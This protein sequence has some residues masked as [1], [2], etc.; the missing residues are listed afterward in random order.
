MVHELSLLAF[1]KAYA[2]SAPNYFFFTTILYVGVWKLGKLALASRR[3]QKR[4][5]QIARK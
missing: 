3:I 4:E 1:F 2:G 5:R